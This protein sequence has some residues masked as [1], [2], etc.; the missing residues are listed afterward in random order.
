MSYEL[1]RAFWGDE[2]PLPPTTSQQERRAAVRAADYVA[3]RH[4][5]LTG[6]QLATDPIIRAGLLELLDA[7]GLKGALNA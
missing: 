6:G 7:L 5:N 1:D 4:P 3:G 2:T